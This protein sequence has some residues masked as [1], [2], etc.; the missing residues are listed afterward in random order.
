MN[1]DPTLYLIAPTPTKRRATGRWALGEHLRRVREN[2]ALFVCLAR[3]AGIDT[4]DSA[5]A[6][7]IA[8]VVGR[9]ATALRLTDA[10]WRRGVSADAIVFPAVPEN[11]ARLRFF[12]TSCHSA[13]QIR[14]MVAALAEE[15]ALLNAAV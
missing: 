7:M 14:F 8:C 12:V 4:A 3:E 10:L 11:Q 2:S 9:S 6:P 15:L 13:E 5:C 1:T